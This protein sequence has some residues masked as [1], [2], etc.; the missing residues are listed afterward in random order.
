LRALLQMGHDIALITH[1]DLDPKALG[2]LPSLRHYVCG[3]IPGTA[4]FKEPR[5][6]AMQKFFYGRWNI[7]KRHGRALR[8]AADDFRAD[9]VIT[10]GWMDLSYLSMLQ[11]VVRV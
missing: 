5:L 8:Q 4:A 1:T 7:D 11:N 3:K 10:V 9:A 6:S 2:G